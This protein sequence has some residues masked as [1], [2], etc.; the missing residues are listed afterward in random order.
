MDQADLLC[1]G[2]YHNSTHHS[3]L[4]SSHLHSSPNTFVSTPLHLS[5]TTKVQIDL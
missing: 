3:R 1:A 4:Q 5:R 2:L